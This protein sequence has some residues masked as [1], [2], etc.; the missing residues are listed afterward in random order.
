MSMSIDSQVL[1]DFAQAFTVASTLQLSPLSNAAAAE[2]VQMGPHWPLNGFETAWQLLA[3]GADEGEYAR[4]QDMNRV[5][6]L[7]GPAV[8][9]PYESVH[10]GDDGLIFDRDT[11]Q[12]RLEYLQLDLEAPKLNNEPDDHIGLELSFLAHACMTAAQAQ[13]ELFAQRAVGVAVDFSARHLL[14][15]GPPMLRA[16]L[17]EA[18]TQWFKGVQTLTLQLLEQWQEL[19]VNAGLATVGKQTGSDGDCADSAPTSGNKTEIPSGGDTDGSAG[20][21]ADADRSAGKSAGTDLSKVKNAGAG[22]RADV[23]RDWLEAL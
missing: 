20:K 9:P 8:V 22:E 18:S 5:Y 19:L 10:T 7:T 15:W 21:S 14:V 4:W 1:E 3:D 12:V 16:A 11:L 13:T 23:K 6:G 17:R 2:L